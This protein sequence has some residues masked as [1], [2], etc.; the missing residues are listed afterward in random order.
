[1]LGIHRIG[2]ASSAGWRWL[3]LVACLASATVAR[4]Q[5]PQEHVLGTGFGYG[6][7][8]TL[9]EAASRLAYGANSV[10][11]T[12]EYA[13]SARRLFWG[14]R[15]RVAWGPEAAIGIHDRSIRFRSQAPD[16]TI[17]DVTV[18]MRGTRLAGA[19]DLRLG[20][21]HRFGSIDLLAGGAIDFV[22]H[23]PDGFVTPGLYQRLTFEPVVGVRMH[24]GDR[25]LLEF[26]ARASLFG[27][28]TRL[29]CHQSV[30]W[31]DSTAYQGLRDQGTGPRSLADLQTFDALASYRYR[32]RSHLA[33]RGTAAITYLR[34][35]DPA[36]LHQLD[37]RATLSFDV[38]FGGR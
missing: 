38:V 35:R 18:P 21:L 17:E 20:Y 11:G 25:Q 29:P 1:M 14:L 23:K 37:A 28:M 31:P 6:R 8:S 27:W 32:L 15:T 26:E 13:G 2:P 22:V 34:D 30:S 36:P 10:V 19:A 5:A 3:A 24:L 12:L 9:D 16:G 4:G 33:L 7:T